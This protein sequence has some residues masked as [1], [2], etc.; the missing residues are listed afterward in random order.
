MDHTNR[1][2]T[3]TGELLTHYPPHDVNAEALC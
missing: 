3:H 2:G 1:R